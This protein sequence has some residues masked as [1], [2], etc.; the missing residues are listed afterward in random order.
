MKVTAT[1]SKYRKRSAAVSHVKQLHVRIIMRLAS[2]ASAPLQR[3]NEPLKH[4]QYLICC[5]DACP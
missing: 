3:T 5:V 2:E 1:I 4:R